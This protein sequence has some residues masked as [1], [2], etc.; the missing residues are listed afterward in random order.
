MSVPFAAARW[1]ASL[2]TLVVWAL[3]GASIVFWALRLAAPADVSAPATVASTPLAAIDPDAIG[4]LLGAPS[5]R[6]AAPTPEAASRFVLS[7][8]VA[9]DSRQGAALIAVDGE[10]PRPFRVGAT[11]GDGYV[12]QA[13]D[14]RTASL[15]ASRDGAPALT[16]Q[17]PEQPMALP[18]PAA[19]GASAAVFPAAVPAPQ[20]SPPHPTLPP[21]IPQM[22]PQP[23]SQATPQAPAPVSAPVATP[24]AG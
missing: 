12:L 17:L 19:Q 21:T 13:V 11:V 15:G 20:A 8:V 18:A 14:H 7:G 1:P 2:S 16:L 23:P 24:H 10:P 22:Q 4:Q 6:A 3:A 9:D 5:T